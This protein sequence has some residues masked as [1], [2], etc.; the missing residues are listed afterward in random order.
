VTGAHTSIAA[1]PAYLDTASAVERF[2]G[3]IGQV[4]TLAID[5]EG[6]SFHRYHDRIYLLQVSTA[7]PI[8]C[9]PGL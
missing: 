1:A 6:A 9:A 8:H 7:E 3:S 4:P 2:V 5:T